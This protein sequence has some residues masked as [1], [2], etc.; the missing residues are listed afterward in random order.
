M[1]ASAYVTRDHAGGAVD[2][3]IT[4]TVTSSG[5]SFT[6]DD[7][8]GWPS[9][10]AAGPFHAIVSYDLAGKEKIEFQSRTGSALTVAD[11]GKRGIDGTSA[12]EHAAGAKIRH[13][14]TAI[15]FQEANDHITNTGLDHHTQYHTAARHAA[16]VHTAA[17]IGADEVGTSEIAP[18]AVTSAE[19]ASGAVTAGKIGV[20]GISAANQFASGVV[21]AAA[22]ATDAVGS[23]EIG[24]DQ[25]GTSEIAPLAVTSAEL[26][27]DSVIAGKIADGGVSA[28]AELADS[29]ITMAKFS[30]ESSVDFGP[31][32]TLTGVTLGTGGDKYARYWK[33]GRLVLM[34]AGFQLGTSGDVTANIQFSLPFAPLD[35]ASG[36]TIPITGGFTA[37]TARDASASTRWS[38]V[39]TIRSDLD[40]A[41]DYVVAG[42]GDPFDNNSPFDWT[43]ED[44][45]EVIIVYESAT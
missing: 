26:A 35:R 15:D 7:P 25:V 30:L 45:F 8:T 6:L 29:I 38:A 21:D 19:L 36:F 33:L 16:V 18:L 41:T 34:L 2:T 37:G 11:T 10:G 40:T 43:N 24:A 28:T 39:G 3:T 22:I 20:G 27:A 31:S 23:A 17:M 13:C 32:M 14:A 1:P 12:A 42:T 4:A 44:S 9:G 5:L